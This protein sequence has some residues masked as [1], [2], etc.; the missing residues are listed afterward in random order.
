VRD[1]VEQADALWLIED[2]VPGDPVAARAAIGGWYPS[3]LEWAERLAGG[4]RRR[5]EDT[6]TWAQERSALEAT[7]PASS[8]DAL[9]AALDVVGGLLSVPTHGALERTNLLLDRGRIGVVSW[10]LARLEGIPGDDILRLTATASSQRA[11][12]VL[13]D[14]VEGREPPFGHPLGALERL[15][16]DRDALVPVLLVLLAR[17]RAE[18][19]SR[20]SFPAG[21][22]AERPFEWLFTSWAPELQRAMRTVHQ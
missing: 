12:S 15:G 22:A 18:E 21:H 16:I 20:L 6:P 10:G 11:R 9:G 7:V 13:S 17:W 8:V 5:L 14:L 4:P 1:A 19:R 3:A 2:L